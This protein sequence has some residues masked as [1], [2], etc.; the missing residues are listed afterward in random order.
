MS[1]V[2]LSLSQVYDLACTLLKGCGASESNAASV[3]ESI[4]QAEADGI[5]NIGLGYLLTYLEHLKCKKVDGQAEPELHDTSA[6]TFFMDAKTGFAHPAID[7]GIPVLIQKARE[8]GIAAMGVGN[9]YACGVLGHLIEP[10]AE[11]G[12]LAMAFANAPAIIAPWG[13]SRPLFGTNPMAAAIPSQDRPPVVIDQASSKVAKVA[14]FDRRRENRELD[15]GWALDKDGKPTQDPDEALKGSMLAIGGYKGVGIAM[16]VEIL[17][18]A[19]TGANWSFTAPLFNDN[20]GGPPKTGQFFVVL[21]PEK[22]GAKDFLIRIETLFSAILDQDGTQLPSDE[23]LAS[24]QKTK[25]QGV[26]L[27]RDLFDRL[28]TYKDHQ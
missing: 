8:N 16:L 6:G 20:L 26:R 27:D 13:G 4:K 14:I 17:S 11:Q 9:S 3:A 7:K 2:Q 22:F 21:D 12:L 10:L 18:A 5:R 1:D 15:P 23:R 25:E 24:R 19:L 28:N